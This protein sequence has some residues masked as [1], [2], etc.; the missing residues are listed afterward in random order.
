SLNPASHA[1]VDAKDHFIYQNGRPVFKAAVQGMAG[2]VKEMMNRHNLGV[3]DIAW[4][5]PH[6]ANL[7]I[8]ESVANMADFP[9]EKVM[10]NIH[11]YGNTTDATLPLCLWEWEDKLKKG[12]NVILTAFGG[13]YTWGATWLKWAY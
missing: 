10:V 5:V 2:V 8:I 9:M 13:G 6:Q 7:R 1:T 11:K 12:D 3:A 4:V